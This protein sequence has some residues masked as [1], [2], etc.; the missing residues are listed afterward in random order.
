MSFRK[1]TI[2]AMAM[3]VCMGA[4]LL[5][6]DARACG[7]EWYPEVMIDHRIHGVAQAEKSLANGNRLA[8]A[9]SVIRMMP[10]IKSLKSKPGSL[11]ARAER[12]LAVALSRS[13]G[14]LPVGARCRLTCWARGAA[15]ARASRRPTWLG[16][17][18]CSKRQ[19][20][21]KSDDVALKT[22]LAEAMARIPEQRAEARTHPGGSG[23]AR[24]DRFARRLRGAGVA[25]QPVRRRRRSEAG[26]QAL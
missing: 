25:A 8:A 21:S 5:A 12:V 13:Q 22:D 19:S 6:Q 10:H 17:S 18:R 1:H 3:G 23:Q 14:A 20:E 2:W 9:A 15:R 24:P 4:G 26:A 11:V 7:G 16:R